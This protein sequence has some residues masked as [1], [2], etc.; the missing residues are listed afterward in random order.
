[1]LNELR[2]FTNTYKKDTTF[3][4]YI[5]DIFISRDKI[6]LIDFFKNIYF[7]KKKQKK[8]EICRNTNNEVYFGQFKRNIMLY[9]IVSYHFILKYLKIADE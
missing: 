6:T 3:R 9:Y 8:I 2:N 7:S 4:S 1:M 5:H